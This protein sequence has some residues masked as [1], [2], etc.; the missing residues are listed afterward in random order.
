MQGT[1]PLHHPGTIIVITIIINVI[2]IFLFT[3]N[4]KFYEY[5]NQDELI[6]SSIYATFWQLKYLRYQSPFR[7]KRSTKHYFNNKTDNSTIIDDNDSDVL[8]ISPL[9]TLD[10]IIEEELVFQ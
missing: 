2:I 1:I 7:K 4:K 6:W 3:I 10:M 8:A 5:I 9:G